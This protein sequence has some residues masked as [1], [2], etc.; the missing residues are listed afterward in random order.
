MWSS[1]VGQF[2]D[3]LCEYVV[4]RKVVAFKS[5]VCYRSGL[6]VDPELRRDYQ[7]FKAA[8]QEAYS[9]YDSSDTIRIANKAL[10][11][12]VVRQTM[13]VA[14]YATKRLRTW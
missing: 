14:G 2:N 11:D 12:Y 8:F 1:F 13:L 9:Q 4:D 7:T 10:N 6:D 5:V 3:Q